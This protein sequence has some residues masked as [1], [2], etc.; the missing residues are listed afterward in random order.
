MEEFN[1][2]ALK[3]MVVETK[4]QKIERTTLSF[5]F[6]EYI[7]ILE[8]QD[9]Y[10]SAEAYLQA[11]HSFIAKFGNIDLSKISA[12]TLHEY[13]K[14]MISKGNSLTTIGIYMRNLRCIFNIAIKN[15]IIDSTKYPFGKRVIYYT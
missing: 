15:G 5:L 2:E 6:H 13:E 3:R 11:L 9:R 7:S 10:K 14:W 4:E 1:F 12:D 8:K